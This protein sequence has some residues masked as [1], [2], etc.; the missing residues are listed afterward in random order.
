MAPP[1]R[2]LVAAALAC[3]VLTGCSLGLVDVVE[4]RPDP[5][6]AGFSAIVHTR[7]DPTDPQRI[8]VVVEASLTPGVG[9]DSVPRAVEE[10]FLTLDGTPHPAERLDVAPGH[11]LFRWTVVRS[12]PAPGPESLRM[13]MP[14]VAELPALRARDL[15]IG[16]RMDPPDSVALAPD[17]GIPVTLAPPVA[18]LGAGPWVRWHLRVESETSAFRW[19]VDHERWLTDVWIPA[20]Q[21]PVDELPLVATLAIL[22][23]TDEAVG[24]DPPD[25]YLASIQTRIERSF[26]IVAPSSPDSVA[27]DGP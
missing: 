21:L 23:R 7:E 10:P 24:G 16:V 20:A 19:S 18:D 6:P 15:Q 25:A 26:R 17:G 13:E 3:A 5:S 27:T 22:L 14:R 11:T 9:P 12:V 8:E 4:P 1:R 2:G